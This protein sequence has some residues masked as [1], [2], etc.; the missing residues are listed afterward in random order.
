[1]AN[2]GIKVSKSGYSVN[3]PDHKQ[4][5]HSGFPSLKIAKQGTGTLTHVANGGDVSVNIT[6]NLGYI[7]TVFVFGK[8][9]AEDGTTIEKYTRYPFRDTFGLHLWEIYNISV[10]TTTLTIS[11][12]AGFLYDK[13]TTVDYFYY[14]CYDP[15]S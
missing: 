1:M 13:N 8:Y 15:A 14:I 9:L 7:P 4:I 12:S 10:T 11:Y 6:H 3:S 5:L 2:C